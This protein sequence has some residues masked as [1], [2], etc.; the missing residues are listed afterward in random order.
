VLVVL[1]FDVE[2]LEEPGQLGGV[3]LV[4]GVAQ[5]GDG[6]ECGLHRFGMN[7]GRRVCLE[8]ARSCSSCSRS[9]R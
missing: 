7:V 5:I 8:A 9:V 2:V 1:D 4:E 3:V 6:R